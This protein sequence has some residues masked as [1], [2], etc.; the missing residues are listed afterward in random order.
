MARDLLKYSAKIL[1]IFFVLLSPLAAIGVSSGAKIDVKL[2]GRPCV[3][4]GPVSEAV[5]KEIHALSPEV[6]YPEDIFNEVSVAH[7]DYLRKIREK[8]QKSVALPLQ[9]DRYREKLG[10]R[11]DAEVAFFDAFL[12]AKKDGKAD[13]LLAVGKRF[14]PEKR[15][16]EFEAGVKAKMPLKTKGAGVQLLELF[17]DGIEPDPQDLFHRAIEKIKVYYQ[18]TFEESSDDD[19]DEDSAE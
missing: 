15:A 8:A 4:N 13:K 1:L 7:T 16:K 9:L 6:V 10:K 18:C 2:F 17:H 5:L 12:Q 3:L 11:L 19:D 14:L